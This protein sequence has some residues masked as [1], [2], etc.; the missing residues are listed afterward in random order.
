MKLLSIAVPCY[1]SQEYMRHCI[2]S[3]LIGGD[4]VEILIINDGSTD[5]TAKIADEY[6][7]AH[8]GIVRA[9]HKENGGHGSAVN[10]GIEHATGLFFKVVDSDDWVRETAYRKILMTL[11]EFAGSETRLD[12]LIS[13]FVYDKVDARH[14]KVMR[15]HRYMPVEEVFTWRELKKFPKG[16]YILMHSV[17]FRTKLLKECGLKLPEHTFY[18][19][20]IY[21]FEPLPF[22]KY[23]YYLDV[24]FYHY[25]IGREDQSVH[26]EVMISRIDQQIR[27]NRLMVDFYT[28]NYGMIASSLQRK[29]YMYNY[30]EIITIISSILL[31]YSG[32]PENLKK[33]KELWKYIRSKSLALYLRMRFS[34]MG[35]LVYLP[36]KGGRFIT[37]G[38]YKL[39]R[40]IYKFN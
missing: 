5:D 38:G 12:L 25:F 1:N 35:N 36:G 26:E 8:P 30:L 7:A 24:N 19:D 37:I 4:E 21:V 9:I 20:N 18:V 31:I 34:G 23:M 16:K 10:T 6:A 22:V 11:E 27:V 13:N 15:Y 29:Q 32:E 14:K 17:I 33:K 39:V 40:K 2:D 3:L 28:E